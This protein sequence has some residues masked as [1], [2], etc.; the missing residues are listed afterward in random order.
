VESN[1][2]SHKDGL[3]IGLVARRRVL[4][5]REILRVVNDG[6]EERTG[7]AS[8]NLLPESEVVERDLKEI[9]AGAGIGVGLEFLPPLHVL[10]LHVVVRHRRNTRSEL[11][12]WRRF[13]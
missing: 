1:N 2:S 3:R 6:D 11:G 13:L 9:A 4:R 7:G 5:R 10:Y 8:R 12:F